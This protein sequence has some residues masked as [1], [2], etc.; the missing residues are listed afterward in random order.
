M[1]NMAYA[2]VVDD[3]AA[4]SERLGIL[5]TCLGAGCFVGPMLANFFTNPERPATLQ[6]VCVAGIAFMMSGWIG[7][8]QSSS[9]SLFCFFS[10]VRGIGSSIIWVNSSILLQRLAAQEILGR[11]LAL[12]FALMMIFDCVT[13]YVTGVLL[14]AG[15]T[16]HEIAAVVSV[17]AASFLLLW[18]IY[19][20][21]GQG[22]AQKKFNHPSIQINDDKIGNVVFA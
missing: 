11:V 6:M 2:H 5:F 20:V 16:K 13:A 9:F 21:L 1:L 3:E 18:S 15:V 22:A 8:S 17:V 19:H 10:L 7:F 12:D 4:T 14:D